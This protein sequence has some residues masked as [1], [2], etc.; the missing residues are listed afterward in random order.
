MT[1]GNTLASEWQILHKLALEHK[2]PWWKRVFV[3]WV[4]ND[5]PLRNDAANLLRRR[6][7]VIPL[8]PGTQ[9]V[10]DDRH[11]VKPTAKELE[12]MGYG[13]EK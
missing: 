6:R 10:G 9:L 7:I 5:E 4:Y 2:G 1:E 12:R 11:R 8:N 3:R 13:S